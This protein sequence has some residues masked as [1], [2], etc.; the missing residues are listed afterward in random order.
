MR[1]NTAPATLRSVIAAVDDDE[2]D[3]DL[4]RLLFRKAEIKN[5]FLV[6][7]RGEDVMIALTDAMENPEDAALPLVCFLDVKMP[8]M[9]GHDILRW[10]RA[11]RPLDVMPVVM[12]T[13]SDHPSDL[14]QAAR[15]G[16]QCYIAKYPQPAVL[17]QVLMEAERFAKGAP[18]KGYFRVP[19]NLLMRG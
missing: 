18:A 4:M 6:Y 3:I 1:M 7:G 9:S 12:L 10:I 11:Q 8:A 13:S 17:R 2:D 15:N 16:A 14:E 5:P 19:S